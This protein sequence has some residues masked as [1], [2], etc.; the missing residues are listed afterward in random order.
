MTK[1]VVMDKGVERAGALRPPS[2]HLTLIIAHCHLEGAQQLRGLL[3]NSSRYLKPIPLHTKKQKRPPL[4]RRPFI[5][6]SLATRSPLGK[7]SIIDFTQQ[8][9]S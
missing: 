8:S 9:F 7:L 4:S 6:I 3:S 1:P 2:P 5:S